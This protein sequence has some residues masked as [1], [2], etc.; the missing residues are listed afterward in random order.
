MKLVGMMLNLVSYSFL[1]FIK[2]YWSVIIEIDS[3]IIPYYLAAYYL[4]TGRTE[5]G[6]EQAERYVRYVSADAAVWQNTFVLLE[7]YEQNT[8][9]YRAGVLRIVELLDAWNQENMGRIELDEQAQAFV[10]R[11]RG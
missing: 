4:D 11:M 5:R 3:N 2:G 7:G 10:E 1:N 8:E 6:L 9:E